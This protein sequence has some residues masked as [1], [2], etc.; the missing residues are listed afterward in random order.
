MSFLKKEFT[1]NLSSFSSKQKSNL[2]K[3]SWSNCSKF[4]TEERYPKYNVW[5]WKPSNDD[6]N[7]KTSI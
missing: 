5:Y 4:I 7:Q 3:E 6:K 1:L 2:L